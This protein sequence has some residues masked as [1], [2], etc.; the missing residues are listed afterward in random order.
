MPHR[1]LLPRLAGVVFG[2]AAVAK[3]ALAPAMVHL[4]ATWGF[5]PWFVR[6]VG[7]VELVGA[8]LQLHPRSASLGG[9]VLV[10]LQTGALFTRCVNGQITDASLAAAGLA[11][12]L[13]ATWA[14]LEPR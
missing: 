12:A 7:A 1:L 4:F 2:L 3:L 14:S 5:P 11:G 8:A 9:L 13:L 6:T 10:S